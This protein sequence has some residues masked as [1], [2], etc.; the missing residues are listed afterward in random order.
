VGDWI[1]LEDVRA[2][3]TLTPGGA[4]DGA[5]DPA[6]DDPAAEADWR[7]AVAV[8]GVVE[9][10]ETATYAV[11]VDVEAFRQALALRLGSPLLGPQVPA[12]APGTVTV[13]DGRLQSLRVDLGAEDP[14]TDATLVM[15]FDAHGSAEVPP[16]PEPVA[17]VSTADLAALVEILQSPG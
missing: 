2:L 6:A 3:G 16:A 14:T 17:R 7:D 10:G 12:E 5:G 11:Q 4:P 9:D 8:T 15:A 13:V 1:E